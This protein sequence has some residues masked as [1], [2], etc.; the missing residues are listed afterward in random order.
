MSSSIDFFFLSIFNDSRKWLCFQIQW[1]LLITG[2]L[3]HKLHNSTW[4]RHDP[5]W[6]S[7]SQTLDSFGP[8]ENIIQP[9]HSSRDGGAAGNFP[10]RTG[11]GLS[12]HI[13]PA[14]G[15]EK[16]SADFI[17][18][19]AETLLWH[20]LGI[21]RHRQRMNVWQLN[22]GVRGGVASVKRFSENAPIN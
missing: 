6:F 1:F 22:R 21:T 12:K 13:N 5:R 9:P 8:S 3:L 17:W 14:C 19:R 18:L 20:F 10:R 4:R 11:A 16:V 15:D 2:G 7:L